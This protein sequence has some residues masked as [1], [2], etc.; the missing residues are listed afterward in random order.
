MWNRAEVKAK[1]KESFKRNYWKSVLVAF[2]Y[3]LFFA[4]SYAANSG[5]TNQI[6]QEFANNPDFMVAMLAILGIVSVICVIMILV[7]IFVLNPLEIGC[8]RFFLKNLE[9]NSELGELGYFYKNNYIGAVVTVLLRNL[10]ITIGCCLFIIP[11]IIFSYSFRLVPYI[12]S[13]EPGISAMDAIKKS[14]QMMKGHKWNSFVYDL[15]FIG[16]IILSA[17]TFGLLALFY[18]NPYKQ[19]SDAALYEAIKG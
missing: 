10:F 13:D 1:G 9:Q 19:S 15:S 4:G 14:N 16:W 17:F 6:S 18:V 7:D 3:L 8:N 2:I 5:N 11:G 12:L